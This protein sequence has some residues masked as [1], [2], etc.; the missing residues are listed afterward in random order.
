MTPAMLRFRVAYSGLCDSLGRAPALCE[1]AEALNVRSQSAERTIDKLRLA[2]VE[3][4]FS[5]ARGA[6]RR[7]D[8]RIYKAVTLAGE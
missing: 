7:N 3:L 4:R 1:V 8:R 2:G 5:D 6:N